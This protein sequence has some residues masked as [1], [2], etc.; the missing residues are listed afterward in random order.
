MALH[1]PA[2][3]YTGG[4]VNLNPLPYVN[5]ALQARA[6]KEAREQAIDQYYRKLPDTLND[7]GVRDQEVPIINDYKQKIFDY[8]QQNREA[9]R[10]PKMD[11]GAAAHGLDKLFREV[12]SVI[13]Q[14]QNAAKTDL[15]L[16]KLWFNKDNQ[17]ALSNDDFVKQHE[18][19]NL[20]VTDPNY[21]PMDLASVM[22]NRPFDQATFVK[23]IKTQFPYSEEV[24]TANDPAN[25]L[26]DIV[27]TSPKLDDKTKQGIYAYAAD[28]LH[29]DYTFKNKI[30]K[31][32]DPNQLTA[33]NDLSQKTFGKPIENDEDLAAAYTVSQLPVTQTK[34]KRAT[35]AGAMMDRKEKFA[36]DMQKARFSHAEVMAKLN[37][38]LVRGRKEDITA[39]DA[40]GYL[41]DEYVAKKGIPLTQQEKSMAV[42]TLGFEPIGY[43]RARDIDER[44]LN[45]ISGGDKTKMIPRTSPITYGDQEIF[46]INNDGDWVG[47]G[48]QIISRDAV[49]D[50]YLKGKTKQSIQIGTKADRNSSTGTPAVKKGKYD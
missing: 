46:F 19:H 22:A 30:S 6:K 11:N 7:K 50:L 16:G 39:D 17:W 38:K 28:K 8:G 23:Q 49:K 33:L 44:D 43:V 14:S 45:T 9:L 26:Y 4:K 32:L 47:D 21:K 18:Q 42:K 12:Q 31:G 40:V 20:P 5:I 2:G 48:G 24:T 34:Q 3:L 15:E 27:T 10:N 35:D 1:N 13:R 29:N 25:P 36:K 37:D 41:T